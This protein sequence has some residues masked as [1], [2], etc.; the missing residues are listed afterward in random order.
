M[1]ASFGKP[2]YNFFNIHV[3]IPMNVQQGYPNQLLLGHG[4][5]QQPCLESP[6][7]RKAPLSASN[8]Y[9]KSGQMP[10]S[11]LINTSNAFLGI[12]PNLPC[13]YFDFP[14]SPPTHKFSFQIKYALVRNYWSQLASNSG[15]KSLLKNGFHH[16]LTEAYPDCATVGSLQKNVISNLAKYVQPEV[17]KWILGRWVGVEIRSVCLTSRYPRNFQFDSKTFSIVFGFFKDTP[18]NLH[19]IWAFYF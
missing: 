13:V 17:C 6:Q 1:R 11:H 5:L 4:W 9:W 3:N 7:G 19:T 16:Q 18:K 2:R 8:A 12:G 15:C 10:L 14:L